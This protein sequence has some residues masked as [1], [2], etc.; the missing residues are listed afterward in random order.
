MHGCQLG[1]LVG[2]KLTRVKLTE[3]Y[4]VKREP[5][6]YS[7]QGVTQL[8]HY[9]KSSVHQ[10]YIAAAVENV[11]AKLQS[12]L[13]KCSF[14][15]L[16]IFLRFSQGNRQ[17]ICYNVECLSSSCTSL[18]WVGRGTSLN[19]QTQGWWSC[20]TVIGFKKTSKHSIQCS[21]SYCNI[22]WLQLM[23]LKFSASLINHLVG[24]LVYV[25]FVLAPL[26]AIVNEKVELY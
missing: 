19:F 6:E 8:P 20:V 3:L 15:G 11:C 7:S 1:S 12:A 13:K 26:D 5:M 21:F 22:F 24:F 2:I 23:R 25:L 14:Y 17:R 9:N 16:K 18:L 10:M 4:S